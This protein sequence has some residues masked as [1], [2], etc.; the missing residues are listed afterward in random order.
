MSTKSHCV[1][2][3]RL[4]E[5]CVKYNQLSCSITNTRDKDDSSAERTKLIYVIVGTAVLRR[6]KSN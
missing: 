5:S 2:S 4:V 3:Y 1:A 6:S